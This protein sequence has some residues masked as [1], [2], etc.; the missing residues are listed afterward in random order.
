MLLYK[1]IASVRDY[2]DYMKERMKQAR[3][4]ASTKSKVNTVNKFYKAAAGQSKSPQKLRKD[5]FVTINKNS[6]QLRN[7]EIKLRTT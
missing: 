6:S 3:N 4:S 7:E 1:S 5:S 2:R